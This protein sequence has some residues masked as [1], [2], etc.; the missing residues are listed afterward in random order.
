[1]TCFRTFGLAVAVG[2]TL[3][4]APASAALVID[5]STYGPCLGLSNCVLGDVTISAA[6]GDLIEQNYQGAKGLGVSGPGTGPAYI[7]EI[8]PGQSISLAFDSMVS[9]SSLKIGFL[10]QEK[11]SGQTVKEIA[12]IFVDGAAD[13][14]TL[15]ITG[16]NKA[17]W[18][19]PD[20][21]VLVPN[22][23]AL[24]NAQGLYSLLD[25][26]GGLSLSLLRFETTDF[27]V[28]AGDD[29]DFA[30]S[31]VTAVAEPAALALVGAGLGLAGFAAWRRRRA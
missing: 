1:M 11:I 25:P 2:A 9:I 19:A 5:P 29:S 26:F 3:A 13:P 23:A 10:Y 27:V 17:E 30:I 21:T 6:G 15:R 14:Y 16:A 20:G 12:K 18:V 22:I 8:N 7:K 4:A 31:G 28:A 24:N